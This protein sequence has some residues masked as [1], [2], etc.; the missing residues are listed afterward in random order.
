[1]MLHHVLGE[2][3]PTRCVRTPPRHTAP[4]CPGV[5]WPGLRR[6]LGVTQVSGRCVLQCGGPGG[7]GGGPAAPREGKACAAGVAWRGAAS[8]GR[9]YPGLG[10][11]CTRCRPS[12]VGTAGTRTAFFQPSPR[13]SPG[14]SSPG[15]PSRGVV[16]VRATRSHDENP[17]ISLRSVAMGNDV[18]SFT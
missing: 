10:R 13:P 14:L 11:C 7:A 8:G 1:M 3:T 12:D 5:S 18:I 9:V 17:P 16:G 2:A 15:C 4:S 6:A